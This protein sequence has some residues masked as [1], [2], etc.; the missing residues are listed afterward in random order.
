M[1]KKALYKDIFREIKKSKGRFFSLMTM[2]MVGV[3]VFVGL[4]I[5]GPAMKE[6]GN[7]YFKS[8][9]YSDA[10]VSSTYGLDEKDV[11]A[12]ENIK[13]IENLEFGYDIDLVEPDNDKVI[14]I[15]SLGNKINNMEIYEGRNIENPNE[16]FLD[17]DLREFYKIGDTIKF[18]KEKTE[19]D[20]EN[21]LKSYDYEIVGF[22]INPEFLASGFKGN[23]SVGDG[24]ISGFAVID[25]DN[26]IMDEYTKARYT[27]TDLIGMIG[28]GT[29]YKNIAKIHEDD[30]KK[31]LLNRPIE[32]LAE[33][34]DKLKSEL[35]DGR[36][37]IEDGKDKLAKAEEEIA[38]AKKDIKKGYNDYEKGKIDLEDGLILGRNKI[39]DGEA[40]LFQGTEELN[41]GIKIFNTQKLNYIAGLENYQLGKKEISDNEKILNSSKKELD[42]A[43]TQLSEGEKALDNG[44]EK[45]EKGQQE[46]DNNKII[47]QK[48]EKELSLATA[49]LESTEKYLQDSK[50][51]LDTVKNSLDIAKFDIDNNKKEIEKNKSIFSNKLKDINRNIDSDTKKLEEINQIKNG[52][53]SRSEEE[54]LKTNEEIVK[55]NKDKEISQNN[56]SQIN[57]NISSLE[58]QLENT[59]DE[60]EKENIKKKIETENNKKLAEE[61]KIKNYNSQIEKE[62]IKKNKLEKKIQSY[63]SLILEEDD[64]NKRLSENLVKKLEVEKT[65]EEISIKEAYIAQVENQWNEDNKKYEEALGKYNLGVKELEYN[66]SL[67]EEKN[68]ELEEGK[69]SLSQAEKEINV[70]RVKLNSKMKELQSAKNQIVVGEKEYENGLTQ[71]NAGKNQLNQANLQLQSGKSQLDKAEEEINSSKALINKSKKELEYGKSQLIISEK[72]GRNQLENALVQLKNGE[73]E[74]Y[75]NEQ[76]F[77]EEKPDIEREI[78]DGEEKLIDGE[79][80]LNS[81]QKPKYSVTTMNNDEIYYNYMDMASRLDI[82]SNIFPIFFFFIA[83]LVSLTTM[84]RMVEE[85]RLQIGTLKAL[86]YNKY[87]IMKKY[88]IYAAIASLIG[89]ILGAIIGNFVISKAIYDAYATM[90]VFEGYKIGL[91]LK[92]III[93]ILIGFTTTAI[94]SA[95]VTNKSLKENASTLMRGK[96]PKS[97]NRILLEKINPIW[98]RLTFLQKVTMRNIFRYKSRMIMTIVG[99]AGCTGL[100]FLGFGIKTSVM[101]VVEKQFSQVIDYD[102]IAV[103]DEDI[104]RDAFTEYKEKINNDNA[105]NDY[106]NVSIDNVTKEDSEGLDKNITVIVPENKEDIVDYVSLKNRK[107][108]EKLEIEDDGVIITEKIADSY[109]LGVGDEIN[110]MDKDDKETVASISGITENYS[111]HYFYMSPEYYSKI[112]NKDFKSNGNLIKVDENLTDIK[113]TQFLEEIVDNDSVLMTMDLNQAFTEIEDLTGSLDVLVFIIIIC[114]SVLAFVVLYNLTNINISE[115]KRELSTIKVLGFYPKEVTQY[116]YRETWLLTFIGIFLG[117]GIG[118]FMLSLIRKRLIP[119]MVMLDP[120]TRFTTYLFSTLI[121]LIFTLIVM[122]TVNKKLKNI[123]MVEALKAVE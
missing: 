68:R 119:D 72:E 95:Y 103:Y 93:A 10:N 22:G 63:K 69:I 85:E 105:V 110:F 26:F 52:K 59:S 2:I 98:K 109:G 49:E 113:K 17:K 67:I 7:D 29:D 30:I 107:S 58:N 114:S 77:L 4:K 79:A 37:K 70:S 56:I 76:L 115:R 88:F 100:L 101:G 42:N 94:V 24:A 53:L 97:G 108:K 32:K 25:K 89:G 13:G 96:P 81:I 74:L 20:K 14:R 21:S 12:L 5:T 118:Q 16:I 61:N 86:G 41:K 80:F 91:N 39:K 54:L 71:L 84:T 1:K 83:L 46:I 47:I 31:S 73:R 51:E 40:K 18:S 48:G 36:A 123:N 27:F 34:K 99:I 23:S 44:F 106:I 38:N 111:N 60:T 45:V 3:M 43:K 87:D 57:L 6:N 122:F 117:F 9:N 112:F 92:Y 121:T 78:A 28:D 50:K 104:N 35:A 102:Y 82:I 55:I 15:Q 116:V 120:Q 8:I 90:Y 64:I 62:N 19:D 75:E 33:I 66:K 11:K 65:L